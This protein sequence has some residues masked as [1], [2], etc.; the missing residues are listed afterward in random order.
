MNFSI[1]KLII[2]LVV[3]VVSC[4]GAVFGYISYTKSKTEVKPQL[5]TIEE[6][7][8][9]NLK[10]DSE[11]SKILSTKLTLEY[12]DKKGA[13]KI[14]AEITR[15]N[16]TLINVFS[17]KTNSELAADKDK[18]KL[19]KELVKELNKTLKEDIITT[20]LFNEFITS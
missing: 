8:T 13:E 15:I 2:Y 9:V 11:G 16:D 14:A 3:L 1:K 12:T 6:K 5:Y 7:I 4:V 19:K 10:K 18:E 17:N 20:V